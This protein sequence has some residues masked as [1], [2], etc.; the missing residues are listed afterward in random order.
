MY[1]FYPSGMIQRYVIN[2]ASKIRML[3]FSNS[4]FSKLVQWLIEHNSTEATIFFH[5]IIPFVKAYT[6]L[7]SV[8]HDCKYR[9]ALLRIKDDGGSKVKLQHEF[10]LVK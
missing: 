6:F 7:N 9:L 2:K 8:T 10:L 3:K 1:I 5:S 4:F